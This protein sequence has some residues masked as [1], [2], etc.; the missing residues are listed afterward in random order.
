MPRRT[1]EP[2]HHNTL[3]CYT[4]Y[5][6]RLPE[7]VERKNAWARERDRGLRAGTWQPLEDAAPVRTHVRTLLA[8]GLTQQRIADLAGVPHQ[9][10]TDLIQGRSRR[11]GLRHRTS[12][13]FAAKILAIDPDAVSASRVDATGSHRRIQALIATGWPLLHIGRQFGMN[14]QRPEQILRAA[15]IYA[16]TRDRV[17]DGYQRLAGLRP[18][19]KGVPRDKARYSRERAA[20]NR[21]PTVA[22][23]ADRMDVIDDPDFEPMYGVTRAEI[24]AQD[25]NEVM[26]LAG[27]NRQAAAE[28]LGVHKS[29]L[30]HAFREFPQYA[31]GVAA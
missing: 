15:R 8:A 20:A 22:Y 11:R 24:V 28:R 27:L 6:C 21:W 2:P 3:T 9:S 14:P 19:R 26:R 17:T 31:I 25:A 16:T 1:G 7:C 10:V 30:D 23:W 18:E 13:E 5:G 29:Y 4:N 12:T